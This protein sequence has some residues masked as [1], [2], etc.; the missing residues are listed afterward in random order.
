MFRSAIDITRDIPEM[1]VMKS[2][3][4]M[5]YYYIFF[6]FSSNFI[7]SLHSNKDIVQETI[8]ALSDDS[9]SDEFFS[10]L[11]II[12]RLSAAL[13]KVTQ[14]Q[15]TL[16]A[17][18]ARLQTLLA[19]QY[20]KL[21]KR[22]HRDA[23][24]VQLRDK[25]AF[26][27]GV[28]NTCVAPALALRYPITL[29]PMYYYS[30]QLAL[31]LFLRY[32]IY[33]SKR[34]HYFVFD[35]CYFVN[36]MTLL[37]L[38]ILPDSR[39]LFLATYGLTHGP[40]AWAIITWRNS[41]VFHSLDKVTSVF[42]HIFPPL[43]MYCVKW[44]P[45][46]VNDAYCD[47]RALA[48]A[49]RDAKFPALNR[50]FEDPSLKEIM[51]YSTVAYTVWQILYYV[52]IMVKQRD[53]VESGLRLTSYS[54]LLD[55]GK[56]KGF[57]QRTAFMFGKKYK[58]EMFMLLQLLYHVLT[59]IPTYFLYRYFWLNTLFLMMIFAV[60]VWNGANYYIEVFSRRYIQE[61]D[62]VIDKNK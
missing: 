62:R 35:L 42:I 39:T 53:K 29:I 52:F 3:A 38:W 15:P 11:D 13:E 48:V 7:M 20:R 26:A 37:F 6:F 19:T 55:E 16:E 18:K 49:F 54:W 10:E 8:D 33:R 58:L 59:T 31:L 44:M 1:E 23:R 12:D 5:Y 24:T 2:F 43:V 50:T 47:N 57:I 4:L 46:L 34:W 41:L 27:F 45:E 40:V 21:D 61:I 56:K 22:M 14:Q 60:S 51:V 17:Q 25:I 36:G 9:S 30:A 28:G 32:F